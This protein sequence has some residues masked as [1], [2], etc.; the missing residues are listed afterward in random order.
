[1]TNKKCIV[2]EKSVKV[3]KSG[4]EEIHIPAPQSK[5]MQPGEFLVLINTLPS[6]AQL[7]F[8]GMESLNRVQSRLLDKAL[9]SDENFLLCAP[10]GAGKTNVAMLA[11][12]R[13][14]GKHII[15]Q[16]TGDSDGIKLQLDAFK[17]VFIAPMKALVQEMV[18]NFSKRLA[19]FG[20]TVAELTGDQQLTRAQISQTQVLVTTPEKWDV[21]TR[22]N[23]DASYTR[24][25]RLVIIDEIHLLHDDRGPVL[26]AIIART[27]RQAEKTENW[28]RLVV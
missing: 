16:H 9:E 15:E 14:I 4:Y 6:W 27:L 10:T 8:T 13:E 5:P 19:P 1:M 26:E 25:V 24:L 20:M 11:M 23:N 21:I 3:Q 18:S 22:K 28:T 12:L 17:I 2:P 7:A